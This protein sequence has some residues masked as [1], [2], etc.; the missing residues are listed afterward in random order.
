MDLIE[1]H[2]SN[3]NKQFVEQVTRPPKDPIKV[4][5][6]NIKVTED[7]HKRLKGYLYHQRANWVQCNEVGDVVELIL[8][9]WEAHVVFY[10]NGKERTVKEGKK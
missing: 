3:R 9:E 2:K 7:C 5:S 6:K 4:K 10:P 8:N 1:R